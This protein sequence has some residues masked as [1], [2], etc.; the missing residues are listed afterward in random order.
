MTRA[1][2]IKKFFNTEGYP[3]VKNQE[4]ITIGKSDPSCLR[5]LGDLCLEALG[6]T[7]TVAS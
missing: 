2:A 4:L 1:Q 6:E 5:E 3:E 7:L